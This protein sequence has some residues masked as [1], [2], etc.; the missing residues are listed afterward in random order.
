MTD[1][2]ARSRAAAAGKHQPVH[3]LFCC[4]LGHVMG[5]I[6]QDPR[7]FTHGDGDVEG[8]ERCSKR[9]V[10]IGLQ[11]LDVTRRLRNRS[12]ALNV[13]PVSCS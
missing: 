13:R 5:A 11:E 4:T 3:S 8:C 10:Q 9:D 7:L 1:N 12:L 6:E 2:G